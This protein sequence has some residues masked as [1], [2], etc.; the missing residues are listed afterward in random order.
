MKKRENLTVRTRDIEANVY[1]I[2]RRENF[3]KIQV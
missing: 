3:Y 1:S 2:K